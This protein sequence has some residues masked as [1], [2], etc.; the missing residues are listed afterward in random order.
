MAAAWLVESWHIL[1]GGLKFLTILRQTLRAV[2]P[3]VL[4][5]WSRLILS[6]VTWPYL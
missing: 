5:E 2:S 6:F 3:F 4:K 1:L